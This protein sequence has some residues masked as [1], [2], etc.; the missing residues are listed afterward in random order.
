MD[1]K[2]FDQLYKKKLETNEA[3]EIS[4]NLLGFINLLIDIDKENKT[5]DRYN[6]SNDSK[7]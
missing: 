4:Q 7:K 5:N 3:F 2:I 6:S 1:L